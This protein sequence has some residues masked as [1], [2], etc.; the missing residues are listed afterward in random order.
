MVFASST[1]TFQ[2]TVYRKFSDW[3]SLANTS[4]LQSC[5]IIYFGAC[6]SFPG[7]RQGTGDSRFPTKEDIIHVSKGHFLDALPLRKEGKSVPLT[8]KLQLVLNF[9]QRDICESCVGCNNLN[10]ERERGVRDI[11]AEK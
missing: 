3:H 8:H 7:G 11:I 6:V 1:K 5:A 4:C 9:C 2:Y 10:R